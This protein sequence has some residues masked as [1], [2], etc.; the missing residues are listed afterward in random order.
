MPGEVRLHPRVASIRSTGATRLLATCLPL[1]L[2]HHRL[3]QRNWNP[4]GHLSGERRGDAAGL[5]HFIK[6]AHLGHLIMMSFTEVGKTNAACEIFAKG[7]E[8]LSGFMNLPDS[9]MKAL[10]LVALASGQICWIPLQII[11]GSLD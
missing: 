7:N 6:M 8:T 9:G 2:F 5:F 3:R 10:R 4:R 1:L 11:A